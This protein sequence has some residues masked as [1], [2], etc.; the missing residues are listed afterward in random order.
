MDS[1]VNE[2]LYAGQAYFNYKG[3]L[4]IKNI[5][6]VS[7]WDKSSYVSREHFCLRKFYNTDS[8]DMVCLRCDSFKMLPVYIYTSYKSRTYE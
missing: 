1:L 7:P 8:N 5:G 4:T 6:M 2:S 3:F